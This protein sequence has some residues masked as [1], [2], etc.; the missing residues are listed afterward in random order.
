MT[1]PT[2]YI[3]DTNIIR[4]LFNFY[5]PPDLFPEIWEGINE[6]LS[7]NLLLSV[8]DVKT[9][10][11]KQLQSFEPALEWFDMN[12]SLFFPP[13]EDEFEWM[14]AL[15]SHKE[16]QMSER[17]I[18]RGKTRADAMLVARALSLNATVVTDEKP[19]PHGSKI[20]TMCHRYEVPVISRVDFIRI[21]REKSYR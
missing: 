15:F 6:M 1:S 19:K 20:P 18:E 9:E 14:S 4:P 16:F 11:E 12:K 17:D 7:L 21:L 10:C 13:T 3:L 8:E 5:Y 2:I